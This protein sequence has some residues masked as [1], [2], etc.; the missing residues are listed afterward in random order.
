MAKA[1][2]FDS[3]VGG[4][5]VARAIA[6]QLPNLHLDYVADDEFR[7]YGAKTESALKAR[8][9][10]LLATLTQMLDS[11][12]IVLACNTASTIALSE[13]RTAITTPVIGVVPA[14]KPAASASSTKTIGVLG[15]PGT[16]RQKYVGNLIKQFGNG[17]EV[18]LR[19]ST[20]LV[21][22]AENK[23][24]G[25]APDMDVVRAEIAPLFKDTARLDHIVL[26]C[27]HFPILATELASAAP[28]AV[29]WIDSADAVARHTR[30]RLGKKCSDTRPDA[31]P[32][33]AF[34]IGGTQ[35]Q[36][37][38]SAFTHY[39]FRRIVSLPS[40]KVPI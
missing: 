17:C 15:T 22:M 40:M 35:N 14:V 24:A 9:P 3:G 33:T 20:A 6:A 28:Y 19:G 8:L 1:L 30:T 11:D 23:L 10:Q 31:Y 12:I 5:T 36:A 7:P 13:I 21:T 29:N 34:L 32:Q 25:M 39:G 18:R 27:T 2:I 16:V 37:R 26:A 4:L 38:K